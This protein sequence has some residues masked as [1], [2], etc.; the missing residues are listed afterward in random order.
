MHNRYHIGNDC[1]N[2][3]YFFIW[4][5]DFREKC[6]NLL[7]LFLFMPAGCI[8]STHTRCI[9]LNPLFFNQKNT[10]FFPRKQKQIYSK[11]LPSLTIHF[12]H[13]SSNVCIPRQ[14]NSSSFEA[15]HASSQFRLRKNQSTAQ[16][17]RD[18]STKTGDSQKIWWV[19]GMG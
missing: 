5:D 7:F 19:S 17:A 10:F 4:S 2:I 18:P 1:Y 8:C 15:N 16:R 13:L 14:K 12:F 9:S 3:N 6:S 11:Y